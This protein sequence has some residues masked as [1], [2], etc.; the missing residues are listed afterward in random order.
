MDKLDS[1]SL[2]ELILLSES[3]IDYQVE[4]WLTVSFATIIASFAAR[5]LLNRKMRWMISFLYLTATFVFA[6][7]W[8]YN[9]LDISEFTQARYLLQ[10]HLVES[11]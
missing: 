3:S 9:S 10:P 4:F 11:F 8:Y 5:R 7:R 6:S 1:A 2:L